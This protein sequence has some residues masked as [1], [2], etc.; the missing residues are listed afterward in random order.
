MIFTESLIHWVTRK[1]SIQF[2]LYTEYKGES[3][4]EDTGKVVNQ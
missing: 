3:V 2:R 1:A 4:V